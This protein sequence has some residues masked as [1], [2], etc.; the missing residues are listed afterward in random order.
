MAAGLTEYTGKYLGETD[1]HLSLFKHR[2]INIKD[3]E[4]MIN[5]DLR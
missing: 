1:P 4:G 2:E 3:R 5:L